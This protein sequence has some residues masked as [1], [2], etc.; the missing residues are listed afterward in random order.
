VSIRPAGQGE[1][2]VSAK[3]K[4]FYQSG[5]VIVTSARLILPSQSFALAAVASARRAAS[6]SSWIPAEFAFVFGALFGAAGSIGK[7]QASL[8]FG[9]ILIG[10]AAWMFL[11]RKTSHHVVLVSDG[12]QVRALSD[13]NRHLIESVV[14]AVNEAIQFQ[15]TSGKKPPGTPARAPGR[16]IGGPVDLPMPIPV[17]GQLLGIQSVAASNRPSL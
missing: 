11:R 13:P 3:E 1:Q 6:K 16:R 2:V 17:D 8:A 12:K 15:K 7:N 10:M 5:H 14:I 9:L 4:V